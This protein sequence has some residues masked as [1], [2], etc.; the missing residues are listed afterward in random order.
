MIKLLQFP[1]LW[2]SGSDMSSDLA[3]RLST[4]KVFH[5]ERFPK[6]D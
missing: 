5:K 2:T 4:E 1:E 3:C 6:M